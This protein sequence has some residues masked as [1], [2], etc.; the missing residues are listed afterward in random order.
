MNLLPTRRLAVVTAVVALAM[1]AFPLSGAADDLPIGWAVLVVTAVLVA[2]GD[3]TPE[4][5][6]N[7]GRPMRSVKFMARPDVEAKT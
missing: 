3:V 5:C 6:S 7:C 4:P 1:L 2:I